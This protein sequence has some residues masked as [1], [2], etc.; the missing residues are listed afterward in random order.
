MAAQYSVYGCTIANPYCGR[1]LGCFQFFILINEAGMS[2]QSQIFCTLLVCV[3][4]I[5]LKHGEGIHLMRLREPLH[6]FPPESLCQ[7]TL[8]PA[9]LGS[10]CVCCFYNAGVRTQG[11]KHVEL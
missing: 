7:V 5:I 11:P 10:F 1:G 8:M 2:P 4:T 6:S 9:L 3:L